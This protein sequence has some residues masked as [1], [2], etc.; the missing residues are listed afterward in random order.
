MLDLGVFFCADESFL[1]KKQRQ[2]YNLLH[3]LNPIRLNQL[4]VYIRQ[5]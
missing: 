4:V 5:A 2:T 3:K 1:T